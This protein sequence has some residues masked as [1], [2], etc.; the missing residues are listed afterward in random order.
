MEKQTVLNI[1]FIILLIPFFLISIGMESDSTL[2]WWSGL[3]LLGIGAV[4]P[5][6]TRFAYEDSE[7]E[8]NQENSKNKEEN[9]ESS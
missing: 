1:T 6:I 9:N 5:T 4:I 8:E 3:I 2:L 7:E